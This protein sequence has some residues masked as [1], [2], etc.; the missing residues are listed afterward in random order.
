VNAPDR[1]TVVVAD[2][3]PH[4]RLLIE[5]SL[6]PLA[7]DGA[8]VVSVADGSAALAAIGEGHAAVAVLDLMLPGMSGIEVCRRVKSDE[9]TAGCHVVIL[10]ARGQEIDR[11]RGEEAGADAYMT[12]PFD[13]DELLEIVRAGLQR[14]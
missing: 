7:L 11:Q 12:K 5:M 1:P 8:R 6:E 4:I 9:S 10:T 2:D 3:E 14:A 13:P